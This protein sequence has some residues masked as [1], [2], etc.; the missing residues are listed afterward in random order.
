MGCC[1]FFV[2]RFWRTRFLKTCYQHHAFF[3]L[4]LRGAEAYNL[5]YMFWWIL[6]GLVLLGIL[7]GNSGATTRRGNPVYCATC[8]SRNLKIVEETNDLL[9][10][11][12]RD[13][14]QTGSYILKR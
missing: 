7:C 9:V 10:Y 1:S 2:Q 14:G 3:F 11:K 4:M 13:C 12:C 5:L 6:G 8:K